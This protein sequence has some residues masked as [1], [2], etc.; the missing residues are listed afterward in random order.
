MTLFRFFKD[1]YDFRVVVSQLVWQYISIRYKRTYVGFVWTLINPLLNMIVIAAVF[2]LLLRFDIKNYAVYLITG[3]IPWIFFLSSLSQTGE[4]LVENESIIKK[5]YIP[6]HVF[7]S[8]RLLGVLIDTVL[9]M[10]VMILIIMALGV[11]PTAAVLFIP[12]SLLLL[13]SP[14]SRLAGL[15]HSDFELSGLSLSNTI[16]LMLISCALG[17]VGSWLAVG[18]HLDAIEPS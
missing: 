18:R 11:W 16:N 10:F 13:D 12:V 14:V 2:S 17:L 9:S 3:L 8:A 7:P 4:S 1:I 15:Y 6:R 5:I